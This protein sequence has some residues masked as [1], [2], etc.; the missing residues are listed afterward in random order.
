MT[1]LYLITDGAEIARRRQQLPGRLVEAWRDLSLADQYW[2]GDESK[3]AL[4]SAGTPLKAVLSLDAGYVPVYYGPRLSD[5][6]SLPSE[7]SLKARVLSAR[8]LAVAWITVDQRGE[9]TAYTPESPTD[10]I[11]FLRRPRG[12]TAHVWRLFRTRREAIEYVQENFRD[13]AEALHW[14]DNLPAE[15]YDALMAEHAVA[16]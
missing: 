12:V 7:G 1:R 11:F 16:E 5:V 10:P 2:V 13:D 4:D 15:S 6:D 3:A 8:G 9:R 14:T